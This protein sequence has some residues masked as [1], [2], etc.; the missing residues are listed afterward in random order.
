MRR[1]A[2][3]IAAFTVVGC[4]GSQQFTTRGVI[5]K[6][7]AP[8]KV[9]EGE[10]VRVMFVPLPEDGSKAQDF[11]V[12]TFNAA[13]SSFEAKGKDGK[14]IPPGKYRVSLEY[15]K[16]RKDAWNGAFDAVNS[17]FIFTIQS[18]SDEVTVDVGKAKK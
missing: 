12:A 9:N 18:A 17:P 3:L 7:G 10:F 11:Y 15:M 4:G 13:D 6:D 14:G 2:I 1:L 5:L 16:N 8:L